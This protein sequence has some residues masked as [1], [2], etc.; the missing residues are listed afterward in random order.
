[1]RTREKK[2]MQGEYKELLVSVFISVFTVLSVTS[3]S[4]YALQKASR[5]PTS[6]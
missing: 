5:T 6:D 1:M 2:F 3:L 4:G